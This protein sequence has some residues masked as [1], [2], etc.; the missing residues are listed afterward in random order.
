MIPIAG[1][2]LTYH[3]KNLKPYL[4]YFCKGGE[5]LK[6]VGIICEYNPFHL[7]HEK[8]LRM[9]RQSHGADCGIVC[10]MSGDFVQR[11]H[12]AIFSKTL[13]AKA[14]VTC[15]ADLVLELPVTAALSSAEGFAA[16]G[17]ALL[18]PWCTHLCFGAETADI[19]ALRN[20]AAAVL[21]EE[22]P[23]VL[24]AL[25]DQ[26]L[27]FPAARAAALSALGLDSTP[28]NHPNN[29]L[30][31]EYCKA[32]VSQNAPITPLVIHRAG[33][34]HAQ[35]PNRENPSA[36]AVRQL[37]YS[38]MNAD[39]YLPTPEIF[40]NKTIHR[41]SAGER[42]I[43]YRLRTMSEEEFSQL[44]YGSEGLWRKLM[45]AAREESTLEAIASRVKSKR[46]T[47][48]RIDRMILCA[49]LGLTGKDIDAPPPYARVLAMND[50]GR[51]ILKSARTHGLY[52][53]TGEPLNHPFQPI[54]NRTEALYGLFATA[55]P[56]S[57]TPKNRII[58]LPN[59]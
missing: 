38:G 21:S 34:Y 53:N 51:Q 58:Y 17:V 5:I 3:S 6:T 9:I 45:H 40:Q 18:S 20:L 47:R 16:G 52:P 13:R 31:V 27:S 41:I 14:A 37:L 39:D 12:P 24:R 43:L 15:G 32:I 19:A 4:K 30:A 28:L 49:F 26:G 23:P 7:G 57:P 22:F 59:T 44:P 50:K 1:T 55:A 25:L 8:Q 56:D 11:G 33:S 48:T 54:E 36:T 29:I 2:I 46:Y 42:A 35:T 10:L